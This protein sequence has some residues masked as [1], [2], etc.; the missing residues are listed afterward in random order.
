MPQ[1]T[2]QIIPFENKERWYVLIMKFPIA[3]EE[4]SCVVYES[5]VVQPQGFETKEAAIANA[6]Q[7]LAKLR[8]V[9]GSKHSGLPR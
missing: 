6:H 1:D 8:S 3:Q 5:S 4:P 2:F 7:Q 9:N